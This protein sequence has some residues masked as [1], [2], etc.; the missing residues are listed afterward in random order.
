[1][2]PVAIG[3]ADVDA[4]IA[5]QTPDAQTRLREMRA[6]IRAAAPGAT[7]AISYGMPAFRVERTVAYYAAWKGHYALYGIRG[8]IMDAHGE[9]LKPYRASKGTVQF[10]L[11]QPVPAAL[12]TK[13]VKAQV[14]LLQAK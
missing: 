13:L 2:T 6:L 4:Y 9:E 3:P 14:K 10:P 1:M 11:D 7:E 5:A 8:E 12:V